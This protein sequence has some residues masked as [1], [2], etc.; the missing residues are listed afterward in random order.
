L[1]IGLPLDEFITVCDAAGASILNVTAPH[2]LA[3]LS[4]D[5]PTRDPF[6]RLLL[7]QASVEA[8]RLVTLDRAL[9]DHPL[10]WRPPPP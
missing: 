1:T 2:V 7:G 10:S 4:P 6:D 3:E 8:M 9:A 5:P